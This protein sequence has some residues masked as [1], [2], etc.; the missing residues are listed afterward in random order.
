MIIS[1]SLLR[2]I[3][4][5]LTRSVDKSQPARVVRDEITGP[6]EQLR[7]SL[8]FPHGTRNFDLDGTPSSRPKSSSSEI[9][10]A[11]RPLTKRDVGPSRRDHLMAIARRHQI[12]SGLVLS[13]QISG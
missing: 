5:L 4:S 6:E 12:L 8:W 7:E 2:R 9:A 1:F 10:L 11:G 13:Q 3:E